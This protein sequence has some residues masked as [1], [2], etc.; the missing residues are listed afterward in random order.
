MPMPNSQAGVDDRK[1][2][3]RPPY[4]IDA[5]EAMPDMHAKAKQS[6]AATPDRMES[7]LRHRADLPMNELDLHFIIFHIHISMVR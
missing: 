3:A 5:A 7:L 1:T 2:S 4:S 6:T